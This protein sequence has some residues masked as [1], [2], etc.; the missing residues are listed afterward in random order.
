MYDYT[1]ILRPGTWIASVSPGIQE[2]LIAE[3]G[4]KEWDRDRVTG[5]PVYKER[6]NRSWGI[7]INHEHSSKHSA[8]QYA[9]L[10]PE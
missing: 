1:K 9:W 2:D 8:S 6:H 3:K 5:I 7:M 10:D 4:W